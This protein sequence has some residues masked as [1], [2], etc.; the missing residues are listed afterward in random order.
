MKTT[1]VEK[2]LEMHNPSHPGWVSLR[3]YIETLGLTVTAAAKRLG[4]SRKTLW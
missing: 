2:S 4:V 1:T 3:L